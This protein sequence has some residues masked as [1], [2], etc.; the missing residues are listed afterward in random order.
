M[1]INRGFWSVSFAVLASILAV[2]SAPG[3]TRA[4]HSS[5]GYTS[6][7]TC[8]VTFQFNRETNKTLVALLYY[9]SPPAGWEVTKV[10]GDATPELSPSDRGIV[11]LG[12][13]STLQPRP[14]TVTYTMSV[15]AGVTGSHSLKGTI[16]YS[17]EKDQSVYVIAPTNHPLVITAI[18]TSAT[19]NGT[20]TTAPRA[21]DGAATG[22][23]R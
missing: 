22:A 1:N 13:L 5:P 8:D 3:Q 19:T 21:P 2:P 12:N 17:Y 14:L 20:T 18:G 10:T 4:S 11:L 6:P 7:G 16:E 15:P 9:V 23:G